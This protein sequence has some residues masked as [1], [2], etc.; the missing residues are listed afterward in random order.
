MKHI[1][2]ED[3]SCICS[4]SKLEPDEK[5]PVHGCSYPYRCGI[6]GKFL[7]IK[8]LEVDKGENKQMYNIPQKE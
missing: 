1:C 7:K 8:M 3:R 5:C 6:C 2:R 4:S